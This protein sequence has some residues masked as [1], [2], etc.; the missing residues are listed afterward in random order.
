VD[1][2]VDVDVD[3]HVNVDLLVNDP[4]LVIVRV[5]AREW[6]RALWGKGRLQPVVKGPWGSP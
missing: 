1:V 6:V 2:D 3:V 5:R 4:G